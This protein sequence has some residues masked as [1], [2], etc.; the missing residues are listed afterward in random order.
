MKDRIREL[1]E[2]LGLSRA[3]FAKET[4]TKGKTWSNVENGLQKV[5]EDHINAIAN[6]WPKYKYWL[7]FGEVMPESGQISPELEA[8]SQKLNEAGK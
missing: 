8:I 3:E 5:N 7:I 2:R 4:N 6:R 1:R